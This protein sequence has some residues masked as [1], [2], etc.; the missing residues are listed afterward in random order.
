[1]SKKVKYNFKTKTI[2]GT[3][4]MICRG[5]DSKDKY[6]KFVVCD[7]YVRV[8]DSVAAVLCSTCVNKHLDF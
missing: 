1:M 8:T 5:S 2:N 3:S 4:H 7:N 6:Y